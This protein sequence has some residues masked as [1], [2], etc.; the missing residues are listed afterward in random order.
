MEAT[1][2]LVANELRSYREAIAR[3]MRSMRPEVKVSEAE[4]EELDREVNR[5]RP[6]F[7][8]CSRATDLVRSAVP[9]WVELYPGCESRSVVSVEGRRRIVEEI[10]LSDLLKV[11]DREEYRGPREIR[12]G[13]VAP[14]RK[15]ETYES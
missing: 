12:P 5:L 6:G 9:V 15:E 10:Q 2:V 4:P 13:T 1:H 11:L 8:V 7:V 14:E 3:V